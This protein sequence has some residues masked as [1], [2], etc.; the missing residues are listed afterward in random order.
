MLHSNV[1]PESD[2][3]MA[4]RHVRNAES[5]I[6]NQRR[7]IALLG[8]RRRPLKQ[9]RELL[10]L[11]EATCQTQVEHL[12]HVEEVMRQRAVPRTSAMRSAHREA[13]QR[14]RLLR[15]LG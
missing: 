9:A 1:L 7:L 3:D 8:A 4:L 2:I 13:A 15:R 5:R 12:S 10:H 14:D 11:F 6:T